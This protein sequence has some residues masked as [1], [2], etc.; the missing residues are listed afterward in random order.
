MLDRTFSALSDPTRRTIVNRLALE[1]DVPVGEIARVFSMSLPAVIKH[2]DVLTDAGLIIRT[3]KGRAVTCRLAPAPM[4]E[5]MAWLT[6]NLGFWTVRLDALAELLDKDKSIMTIKNVLAGV[7]VAD[8]DTAVAWYAKALGRQPDTRPMPEVAE[9]SF[10]GGGWMQL[11]ADKERAGNSSVTLTVDN[12]DG[13]IKA[14]ASAG[15][16]ADEPTRTDLVDTAT[17]TDPDGNRLVFAQAKSAANKA[18]S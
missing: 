10:A 6:R 17:V 11:F 14:L 12:L 15:I 4:D 3:R 1:T 13:R 9:Y 18:A 5:A 7:A 16:R 2:L 8:L